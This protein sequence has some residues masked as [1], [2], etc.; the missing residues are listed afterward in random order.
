MPPP[1][2]LRISKK[3]KDVLVPVSFFTVTLK[4]KPARYLRSM[5][6]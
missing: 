5:G 3:S 1:S 4:E 2:C 6:S